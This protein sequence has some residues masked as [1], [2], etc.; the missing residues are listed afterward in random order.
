MELYT[1]DSMLRREFVVEGWSSLI[2]TERFNTLG[3]FELDIQ[4]TPATRSM[5]IDDTMLVCNRSMRV[6]VIDTVTNS[7]DDTGAPMLKVTGNMIET[8]LN[9]RVAW[10]SQTDTTSVPSWDFTDTPMNI[11]NTIFNDICVNGILDPNDV[12][13]FYT[14]GNI[15]PEDTLPASTTPITISF[16]PDTLLN[17]LQSLCSTYGMGYRLIRAGDDSKLYFNIYM[18]SDRTSS[19]TKL[20]PVIFSPGYDSLKDTT[21]VTST[22]GY[23]NVAYVYSPVGSLVVTLE[24]VDPTISGFDR[25][26]L[27]VNADDITD[28]TNA[29]ALLQQ[30]GVQELAANAK[31]YGFDGE[32]NSN[33]PYQ[34]HVDYELGDLVELRN[35]D[36]IINQ[37]R[38][39]EQIFT[40]DSEG[41]RDYPTLTVANVITPGSWGGWP[42]DEVWED[43][44][45]DTTTTWATLP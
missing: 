18:G 22:S 9:D 5:L 29:Q 1:L 21:E 43:Y 25:H 30:R 31:L 20:P 28:A 39:T 4:S 12:I 10:P 3:D 23:K 16:S 44:D 33:V 14:V 40:Q 13:P 27:M 35:D 38:V 32:L 19:Q 8:I 41:E 24:D 17:T 45:D 7:T 11:A 6:G 2:W 37:M 26:V 42:I 34:Y 15:L 36:G